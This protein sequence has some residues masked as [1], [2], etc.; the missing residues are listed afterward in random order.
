M[1]DRIVIPSNLQKR[2][3][4]TLHSAHQGINNMHSRANQIIYWSGMNN[5]TRNI[6]YI[7]HTCDKTAPSPSKGTHATYPISGLAISKDMC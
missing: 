6:R 7:Y 1:D 2:V 3:L 5:G 4:H